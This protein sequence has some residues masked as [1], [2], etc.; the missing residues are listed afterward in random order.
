[1]GW[2]RQLIC[3]SWVSPRWKMTHSGLCLDRSHTCRLI[4]LRFYATRSWLVRTAPHSGT[5]HSIKSCISEPD[6]DD[7]E[8]F[9]RHV[10]TLDVLRPVD[11]QRNLFVCCGGSEFI[12]LELMLRS[13][14]DGCRYVDIYDR[15]VS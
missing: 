7:G 6:D 3:L 1:M 14:L 5:R 2:K 9:V 12:A 13:A 15:T 4:N 11:K 10:A 8:A